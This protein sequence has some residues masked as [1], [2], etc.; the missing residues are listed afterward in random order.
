MSRGMLTSAH[1]LTL[2]GDREELCNSD[3][4]AL[5]TMAT[6]RTEWHQIVKHVANISRPIELDNQ[7]INRSIDQSIDQSINQSVIFILAKV[8]AATART[9]KGGLQERSVNCMVS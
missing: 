5:S 4:H 9:T 6:D 1:L 3:L 8:A 2:C 7:S